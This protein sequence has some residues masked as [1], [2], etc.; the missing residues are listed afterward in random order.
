MLWRNSWSITLQDRRLAN[1]RQFVKLPP[2][3]GYSHNLYHPRLPVHFC[4][5]EASP[6]SQPLPHW[7]SAYSACLI[8]LNHTAYPRYPRRPLTLATLVIL[9]TLANLA[10]YPW[11]P[12]HTR[13]PRPRTL[14]NPPPPRLP[15]PSPRSK[16]AASFVVLIVYLIFFL[17]IAWPLYSFISTERCGWT[18]LDWSLLWLF[19]FWMDSL[20]SLFTPVA[21]YVFKS[22]SLAMTRW[23]VHRWPP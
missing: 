2:L 13:C 10:D 21:T 12:C 3:S 17:L 20:F 6:P 14:V 5:W 16:G 11:H 1:W 22:L 7:Q 8:H 18:C 9:A 23:V 15:P 19:A 4:H